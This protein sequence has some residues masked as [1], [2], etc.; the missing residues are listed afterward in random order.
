MGLVVPSDVGSSQIRDQTCVSCIGRLILYYG[1]REAPPQ[2][3]VGVLFCFVFVFL[4][5]G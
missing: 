5:G 1:A 3:S 4:V 2:P